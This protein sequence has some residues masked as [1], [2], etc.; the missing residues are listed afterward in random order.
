M[1]KNVLIDKLSEPLNGE[2][3]AKIDIYA[4]DGNLMLDRHTGGEQVLASGVLQYFERQ[5]L[6]KRTLVSSQGQAILTLR[7]GRAGQPWFHFPWAACNG[8]TD[9]QIHIRPPTAPLWKIQW[10]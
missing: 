3:T 2:M 1:A 5:G 9:W 7:G 8:A 10:L 6:P 4:G